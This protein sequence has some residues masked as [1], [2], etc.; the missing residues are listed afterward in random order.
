MWGLLVVE[1]VEPIYDSL[2]KLKGKTKL[3]YLLHII[4]FYC[5]VWNSN[6]VDLGRRRKVCSI[7]Q[8]LLGMHLV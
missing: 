5:C 1:F 8:I 6:S 4:K 7:F 3:V 2:A